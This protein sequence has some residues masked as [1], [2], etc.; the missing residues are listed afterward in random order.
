[1]KRWST[2]NPVSLPHRNK[3]HVEWVKAYVT[4][5]TELQNYIKK[6]H[7]TGLTWSKSVSLWRITLT[8]PLK[9]QFTDRKRSSLRVKKKRDLSRGSLILTLKHKSNLWGAASGDQMINDIDVLGR[10]RQSETRIYPMY[11]W[12]FKILKKSINTN[13]LI[14]SRKSCNR[15]TFPPKATVCLHFQLLRW[16]KLVCLHEKK[17]RHFCMRCDNNKCQSIC[18][19]LS[20]FNSTSVC[21]ISSLQLHKTFKKLK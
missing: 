4:I 17:R 16:G 1:M 6:Y 5:W 12:Y 13:E 7:T 14:A 11:D 10:K 21:Q 19:M 20:F 3:T 15:A 8:N 9:A 18:R 2:D